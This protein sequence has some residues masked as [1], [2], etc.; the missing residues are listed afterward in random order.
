MILTLCVGERMWDRERR[1]KKE[2]YRAYRG[3]MRARKKA[4]ESSKSNKDRESAKDC[5]CSLLISIHNK[6]KTESEKK[7]VRGERE[8]RH[9]KA[10]FWWTWLKPSQGFKRT[11]T[12]EQVLSF[13]IC[14][15][16]CCMTFLLL[17]SVVVNSMRFGFSLSKL[18]S[19]L[20]LS[21]CILLIYSGIFRG[22]RVFHVNHMTC[23]LR[24]LS[25]IKITMFYPCDQNLFNNDI[26]KHSWFWH[27]EPYHARVI[28]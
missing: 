12:P 15:Y 20:I 8:N 7:T 13:H 11:P 17:Y 18:G 26:R 16:Y 21:V 4:T 28:V 6:K 10:R 14:T 3:A 27:H 1:R 2:T 24:F 22:F 5:W 25:Q 23:V 19:L 9:K